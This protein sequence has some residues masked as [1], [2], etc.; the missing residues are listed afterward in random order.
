MDT[1]RQSM[2]RSLGGGSV[3]PLIRVLDGALSSDGSLGGPLCV[4]T[5]ALSMEPG[6]R[7]T[8]G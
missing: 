2:H 3:R 7:A 4:C 5:L 1:N 6:T 8:R